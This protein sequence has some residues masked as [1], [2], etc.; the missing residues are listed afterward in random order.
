MT[1]SSPRR[2]RPEAIGEAIKD[3]IAAHGLQPGDRLPQESHLIEALD[4]AKGTIRE[5]MRGLE[6]QGLIHTRTGPGGGAFLSEVSDDRAMEL[7]GN[8]FFFRPPTIHDIY[9]VR[10]QLEPSLVA[11]LAGELSDTDF[12][13]LET[14]MA[15]YDHPSESL[16]EERQ[17]RIKELEFHLLLVDHCPNPL[18]ALMC[19]FPIRL[20]MSMTTCQRIYDQ[21]YPELRRRGHD[22]QRRLI[23][24]LRRQDTAAAREIMAEHMHAAQGLMEAREAMLERTFFKAGTSDMEGPSRDYLA[25]SAHLAN[26]P[27]S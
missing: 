26:Q 3:Y 14:V 5:A 4:A 20:L 12:Q 11:S 17:Q 6:S 10:K 22:Y 23:E 25:L 15:F 27:Q 9:E 19:R 13:R 16:D 1:R 24:A 2:K 21:P 8:Y 7:M 18:L